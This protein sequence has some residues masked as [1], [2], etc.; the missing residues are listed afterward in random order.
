MRLFP[1]IDL[2]NR[3]CVRLTQGDFDKVKVYEADP[4]RQAEKFAAA[5]ATGLHVVDLD[6]AQTGESQQL[7]II[8]RLAKETKLNIQT[9]GGIRNA[10]TIETLLASGI[11]RVVLGSVAVKNKPLVQEWIKEFGADRIVLAFDVKFSGEKPEVLTHGWQ[12][13]SAESL[14]DV[15][16]SYQESALRHILCTDVSRDGM[17]TGPNVELYKSIREHAPQLDVLASGGIAETNDLLALA[18]ANVAGAII[19][20]AIYEG[21]IDLAE[22]LAQVKHAG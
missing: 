22:A 4:L 19:G 6:G 21:R 14:W 5:G 18:K 9:G 20:K 10:S 3:Q 12:S 16:Q 11:Q 8:M 17:L 15:L 13:G 7:D 1:A 2:K